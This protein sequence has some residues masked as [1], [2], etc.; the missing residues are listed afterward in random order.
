MQPGSFAQ[1]PRLYDK[2]RGMSGNGNSGWN[3]PSANQPTAAGSAKSGVRSAKGM[4]CA[5]CL[6]LCAA[7][8]IGAYFLFSGKET[9]KDVASAKERGRIK[10][11]TPAKAP[12]NRV[13]NAATNS[14]AKPKSK[15]KT[16]R[17]AKGV[18]RYEGG[19]VVL[20]PPVRTI[21]VRTNT[22]PPIFSHESE[23]AIQGL[24][25][26]EPGDFLVGK[27][28][29]E[30]PGFE[31]DFLKSCEEPIII[32]KDDDEETAAIKRAVRDVK[33][34]LRQRMANGEKVG[35][36]L[37]NARE[38]YQRLGLY[39]MEIQNQVTDIAREKLEAGELTEADLDDYVNAA[40]KM[41]E[42][43]GVKPISMPKKMF[44]YAMRKAKAK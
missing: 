15:L 1:T 6:V 30:R 18:L 28:S 36:I 21:D 37:E 22:K 16:Y 35:T 39:R 8:G 9:R 32:S 33:I 44:I 12:T 29:Y 19:M 20:K 10:E 24:L 13:E 40:N 11:V 2:I 7:L 23:I 34:E 27:G 41:L 43:K 31:E 25:D 5:L 14:A 38:E 3:R 17:D 4:L 42:Q 26:V